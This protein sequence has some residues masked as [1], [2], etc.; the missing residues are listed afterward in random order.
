[1]GERS[2]IESVSYHVRKSQQ[3]LIWRGQW[4]RVKAVIGQIPAQGSLGCQVQQNTILGCVIL[5]LV[6]LMLHVVQHCI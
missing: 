6:W 1:M 5:I 4:G 2:I 3:K